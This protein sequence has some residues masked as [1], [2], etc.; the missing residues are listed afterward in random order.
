MLD[1]EVPYDANLGVDT[2]GCSSYDW[3]E[4]QAIKDANFNPD[5]TPIFHY[6]IWADYLSPCLGST[7]GVSR[8]AND[9]YFANGATDFIVA[10]GGWS[11]GGGTDYEKIGTFMHELGHNLG[12]KH[13]GEDHVNTS[14]IT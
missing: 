13:G 3:S 2:S 8:N 1:N 10:L 11:G 7:S 12:L 6:M 14:P 5:R 9:P 4:F